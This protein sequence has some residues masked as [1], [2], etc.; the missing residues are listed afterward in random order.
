[1]IGEG[2]NKIKIHFMNFYFVLLLRFFLRLMAAIHT[3]VRAYWIALLAGITLLGFGIRLVGLTD[4]GV[5]FDEAIYVSYVR[6]PDVV[7]MLDALLT[8]PP[9]TPLYMLLLDRWVD[10]FGSGDFSIRFLAVLLSTATLPATYWLGRLLAGSGAGLLG[11]LLLAL[12]PY[13]LELGQEAAPYV[14][15]SFTTTLAL[16]LGWRWR[17]TGRGGWWYVLIGVVAGYSHYVFPA[18]L[19]GFT[20]LALLPAA[21]PRRLGRRA[22]L[23][24]NAA[25]GLA[26]LPWL[27]AM[28][29]YWIASPVPRV[30]LPQLVTEREVIGALVQFSSGSA[31]L[32]TSQPVLRVGGLAAGAV[33]LLAG[34][35]AGASPARR[36]LRVVIVLS[37]VI[38][39]APAVIS[40]ATSLWI[41]VPHFMIFLL[42]AL[43]VVLAAGVLWLIGALPSSSV[44]PPEQNNT[45]T[46]PPHPV[47]SRR[48]RVDD[49]PTAHGPRP[50]RLALGLG[51]LAVWLAVHAAGVVWDHRYPPHG[52]DGLRELAATLRQEARPGEAVLV[53][54][55]VLDPTLRQYYPGTIRGLPS[56]FNLW[57]IF[58]P[59]EP[60][61]WNADS[62]AALEA[63]G[64]H[65]RFWL[66]YLPQLDAGGA[67]LAEVRRRYREVRQEPYPYATL[68]LFARP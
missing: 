25:I 40:A 58:I 16:A 19:A 22:W 7:S 65:V 56:D 34:W 33:L 43:C 30:A 31:V 4:H 8:S 53:T 28:A 64:P 45:E 15:A 55:P 51:V 59:Y 32:L 39:L 1:V 63:A 27:A 10:L 62:L 26:W 14:L 50:L 35:L 54:P 66:V 2:K 46:F 37:A 61:R 47:L 18:I 12:S 23:A 38:F 6:L 9:C 68:Y 29:V 60:V 49:Q 17:A 67:F 41:F 24:G 52:A 48:E 11:A 36:G 21:G 44:L 5:W 13:A 57:Q 3:A 42:P 20:V